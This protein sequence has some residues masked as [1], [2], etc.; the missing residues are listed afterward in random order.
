[1]LYINAHTCKIQI[2]PSLARSYLKLKTWWIT[3]PHAQLSSASK[4]ELRRTWKPTKIILGRIIW[5][6]SCVCASVTRLHRMCWGGWGSLKT[7]KGNSPVK[8]STYKLREEKFQVSWSRFWC[9]HVQVSSP[10]K[11]SLLYEYEP[12][13]LHIPT[14][15]QTKARLV[16]TYYKIAFFNHSTTTAGL[17]TTR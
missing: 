1:M 2:R 9:C 16:M 17:P 7:G 8:K 3:R 10:K 13:T 12:H 4:A 5:V 6:R 14:K 15:I 11:L